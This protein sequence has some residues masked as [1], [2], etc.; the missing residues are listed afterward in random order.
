LAPA[1][2]DIYIE[3]DIIRR[4]LINLVENALKYSSEGQRITVSAALMEDQKGIVM[5][6]TDQGMGVPPEY[7]QSIFKKFERIKQANS[8]S[9]GLGLGLAFCRLAVEAHNGRIW[10]EDAP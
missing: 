10:V 7:R 4:V 5:A 9:K 8:D 3:E 1:L 6:V 2:P